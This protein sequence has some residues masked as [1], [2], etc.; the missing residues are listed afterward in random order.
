[1]EAADFVRAAVDEDVGPGD[2]TTMAV[3]PAELAGKAHIKAKADLVVCGHE[4]AELAFVEVARRY[5]GDV[6]YE[7]VIPDGELAAYGDIVSRVEAPYRVILIAERLALNFM[8]KLSGIATNVRGFVEAAGKG[9]EL[10]SRWSNGRTTRL[11]SSR[12]G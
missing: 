11:A 4:L 10:Y 3:V 6:T 1:M 7:S 5:G 2:L 9:L 8:M 12:P